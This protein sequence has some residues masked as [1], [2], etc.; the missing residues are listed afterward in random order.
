M[1]AR[2]KFGEVARQASE[3]AF[4]GSDSQDL[5]TKVRADALPLDPAGVAVL[6]IQTPRIGP[7][8]AKL[9][10]MVT[11][12][13]VPVASG[14]HVRIH[15]DG[16]GRAPAQ[17]GGL[18]GEQ[19]QL[20]FRLDVEQANAG[21]QGF[22][23]FLARF[24]YSGKNHAAAIDAGAAEAVELAAGN[25]VESGTEAGQQPQDGEI[26]VGLDRVADGVRQAAHRGVQLTVGRRDGGGAVNI[27]GSAGMGCHLLEVHFFAEHTAAAPGK[28]A[29]VARRI[30]KRRN[31]PARFARG[32]FAR[33]AFRARSTLQAWRAQ[34]TFITTS[35]R[36][37]VM[38]PPAV[39]SCT[40]ASK[41]SASS[42]A[43]SAACVSIN[44]AS[45]GIPNSRPSGS[46]ASERPSE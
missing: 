19:V 16:G 36:S 38:G 27:R 45:R 26:R 6:Q 29:G 43:V 4:E 9:V 28:T 3:T 34:L 12:R 13:D 40:S 31:H 46:G 11:G 25:D 30:E 22:A 20:G 15:A 10:L 39:N 21:A 41:R 1:P 5:R 14:H 23:N 7:V 17:A 18:C 8:D 24:S 44:D 37:S 33:G 42:P 35:V 32:A 2:G